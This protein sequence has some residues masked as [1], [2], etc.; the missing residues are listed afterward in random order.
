LIFY[1]GMLFHAG[2]IRTPDRLSDDPAVG[3]LT[4]NGFFT[5]RKAA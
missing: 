1:D 5:C 2:D 4:L 3:R